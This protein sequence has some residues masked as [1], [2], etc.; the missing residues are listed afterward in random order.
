MDGNCVDGSIL[1]RRL[2]AVGC[3]PGVKTPP[4]RAVRSDFGP[5]EVP[6]PTSPSGWEG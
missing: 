6:E 3:S 4:R 1:P 5:G 2:D